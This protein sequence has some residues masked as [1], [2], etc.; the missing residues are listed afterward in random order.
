MYCYIMPVVLMRRV[1]RLAIYR[2][3]SSALV[4]VLGLVVIVGYT[5]AELM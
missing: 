5:L 3:K 2:E 4:F 1:P